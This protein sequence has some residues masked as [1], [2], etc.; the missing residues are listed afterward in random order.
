MAKTVNRTRG[1]RSAPRRTAPQRGPKPSR[2]QARGATASRTMSRSNAEVF[3]DGKRRMYAISPD[4]RKKAVRSRIFKTV[5]VLAVLGSCAAMA[6]IV[7]TT[8]YRFSPLAWIPFVACVTAV[9]VAFAYIQI[10][11]R[12]LVLLEK[13]N[14]KD[15]R[16]N[17]NVRFLVRF[18]NKCPLFFFRMEAHFFT[19]DAYGNPVSHAATTMAL[20]PFEKYDMPFNTRFEHI[21]VYTAGLDRVVVYDFLRLFSATVPGTG[22]IQV[23]VTPRLVTVPPLAFSTDAEVE[24]QKAVQAVIS[25]SLDYAGVREYQYGDPMKSVHWKLS[26]RTGTLMTRL[27]EKQTN[28]GVAVVMDFYGPGQ[29][30]VELMRMFDAVVECGFSVARHALME[31]METEI[32]Y[33]DRIGERVKRTQWR[34]SELPLI[35]ADLP[36]FSSN[37]EKASDGLELLAEQVRGPYGQ[38]NIVVC[39][40]N[41]SSEMME[42]VAEAKTHKR[43]PLFIAVV[44]EDLEGRERDRW[45]APLSRLD[46]ANVFYIVLSSSDELTKAGDQ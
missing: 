2:P 21:G 24:S 13:S 33:T 34:E 11:K 3:D 1:A 10:L 43:E 38:N 45:L 31:G 29:S 9:V 17:E 19:A 39:S 42:L 30:A 27:F 8:E 37:P 14:V 41:I 46:A 32:C 44:P 16:R 35:V 36:R 7:G 5:A 40:A 26:A 15:C 28:P 18:A 22:R 6:M 25:D 20:A 4:E 23:Q 12:S